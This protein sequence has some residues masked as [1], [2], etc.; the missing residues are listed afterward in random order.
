MEK[1]ELAIHASTLYEKAICSLK[2]PH[3]LAC[4]RMYPDYCLYITPQMNSITSEELFSEEFSSIM[5]QFSGIAQS[6]DMAQWSYLY[7][8]FTP[9][10]IDT[11]IKELLLCD[12]QND[13]YRMV[14]QLY[15]L[16]QRNPDICSKK[17]LSYGKSLLNH[18]GK[19]N[20]TF[21]MLPTTTW[22]WGTLGLEYALTLLEL[23][24]LN[25]LSS[26]I[27]ENY[28]SRI[29]IVPSKQILIWMIYCILLK[30]YYKNVPGIPTCH[31]A[32]LGSVFK[33]LETSDH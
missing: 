19:Y 18:V 10:D 31:T 15:S 14:E 13:D 2:F 32:L 17:G 16:M 4:S 33:L 26:D 7:H 1:E 28:L 3:I 25:I 8:G 22:F 11:A 30:K 12:L 5:Y 27:M 29:R 24:S 20:G 9:V 6:Q 21:V 23:L